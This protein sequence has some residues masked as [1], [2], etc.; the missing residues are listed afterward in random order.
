[1]KRVFSSFDR[2]AVFHAR[3]L[4]EAEGIRA[5]VKN[6]M[7]SSAMGELPPA[8]CQAE[9]W[10]LDDAEAARAERVLR[11]GAAPAGGTPWRCACGETLEAQF[12]QCWRCGS[13]RGGA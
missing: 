1:M 13:S 7:L 6:E 3:N 2:I 11:E 9:V 4:L 10:V 8:E 12:L 5:T